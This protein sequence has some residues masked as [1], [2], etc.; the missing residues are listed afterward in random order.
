MIY[1]YFVYIITNKYRTVYYIGVTNNIVKR[2]EQH[3]SWEIDGFT[4]KYNA[5]ILVYYEEFQYID[6]AILR[7]KQLKWWTRQ[8]KITLIKNNNPN[9]TEIIYE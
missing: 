7:E 5:N 1:K 6:K 3:R 9:I 2:I 8:K 4:K